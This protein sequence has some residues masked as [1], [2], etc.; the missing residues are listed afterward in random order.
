MVFDDPRKMA[1]LTLKF[2]EKN[3][4]SFVETFWE[5]KPINLSHQDERLMKEITFGVIKRNLSLNY[6]VEKIFGKKMSKEGKIILKIALYQYLFLDKIPLY[7]IVNTT[8]E[9]AKIFLD[10][11]VAGYFN[12][13]LR[14]INKNQLA[15]PRERMDIFYSYPQFYIASLL[16]QYGE[17]KTKEILEV[18]NRPP[19]V[20]V[21]IRKNPTSFGENFYHNHVKI[22][23]LK[24]EEPIQKIAKDSNVYI[25]NFTP[26]YLIEQMARNIKKEEMKIL[27]L[28]SSPGGKLI[29]VHDLFPKAQLFAND[30]SDKKLDVLK[31]NLEKYDIKATV[32]KQQ[33]EKFKSDLKFDLIIIDA[34]CSNSGVLHKRPEARW[35][36]S[37]ENIKK[38]QKLQLLMLH[39]AKN[40]LA[41]EGQVWYLTCSILKQENEDVVGEVND[42]YKILPDKEGRDGGFG[43]VLKY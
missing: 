37:E 38:Q 10:S 17:E 22:N 14:K 9:L 24:K 2:F 33:A 7:A 26:A 28:C 34:P 36:L 16:Q 27:D 11:R 6:L 23:T 18:Q 21:R 30:V 4:S 43:C 32:F 20:M 1:F 42:I 5:K 40:L 31:Q 41:E 15:L 29:L 35:R 39:N 25:Q 12:A 8:V 3:P 13:I 19:T